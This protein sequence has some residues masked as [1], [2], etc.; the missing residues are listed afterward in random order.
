VTQKQ[1]PL[2]RSPRPPHGQALIE[3]L[4]FVVTAAVVIGLTQVLWRQGEVSRQ[5][6][7]S[8]WFDLQRCQALGALCTRAEPTSGYGSRLTGHEDRSS[9]YQTQVRLDQPVADT[10][11]TR[12]LDRISSAL[13]RFSSQAASSTFGLPDAQRLMRAKAE[14]SAVSGGPQAT[15]SVAM[16]AHDWAASDSGTAASRVAQGATPS[17]FLAQVSSGVYFPVTDVLMPGLEAIGLES[18][19]SE[20]RRHFHR[21][22]SLAPFP[23]TTA[24]GQR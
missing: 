16:I 11:G 19:S 20:F 1:L 8:A 4:V 18:G 21:P 17:A 14:V 13:W 2:S 24:P 12:V 15:A 7:L 23:G 6:P 3:T 22:L 9:P 10:S 5:A